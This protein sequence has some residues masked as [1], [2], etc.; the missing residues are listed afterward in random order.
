MI[1]IYILPLKSLPPSRINMFSV[2]SHQQCKAQFIFKLQFLQKVFLKKM[3][4]I[5]YNNSIL[6]VMTISLKS[7]FWNY[8]SYPL[9]LYLK[10]GSEAQKFISYLELY[11]T[12]KHTKKCLLHVYYAPASLSLSLMTAQYTV[13]I[14]KARWF[15]KTILILANFNCNPSC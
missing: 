11:L 5:L 4:E 10:P 13:C 8:I 1:F 15:T 3:L 6:T 7:I 2:L 14:R 12:I 9:S